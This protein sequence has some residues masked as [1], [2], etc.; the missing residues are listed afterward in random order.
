MIIFLFLIGLKHLVLIKIINYFNSMLLKKNLILNKKCKICLKRFNNYIIFINK[1]NKKN[2][3]NNINKLYLLI[4]SK[5]YLLFYNNYLKCLKKYFPTI[6][7]NFIKTNFIIFNKI[8]KNNKL[9]NFYLYLN[10]NLIY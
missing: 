2:K 5:K 7:F 10:N 6:Y 8:N 9:Y 3:I 4:K 1:F